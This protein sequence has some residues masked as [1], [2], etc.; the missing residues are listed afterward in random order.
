[1]S[2][3]VLSQEEVDALLSAMN[4]GEVDLEG[5]QGETADVVP[6]DLT[7]QNRILH[8]QFEALDQVYDIF[9]NL[10]RNSLSSSLRKTVEVTLGSSEMVKFSEFLKSFSNPTS[11]NIF[12]MSPLIGSGMLVLKPDLVFPLIDCMFGGDGKSVHQVRE[13]TRIEQG[14]IKRFVNETLKIWQKS[15]RA[16]HSVEVS[17]K[18]TETKPQFVHLVAPDDAVIITA[19]T[20]NCDEFSEN[21]YLC[22]PHIMLEPIKDKLSYGSLTEL[23]VKNKCNSQLQTL[24]KET[25]VSITVEL[26][27]TTR[28]VG[29]LLNLQTGDIINLNAGPQDPI[30]IKVEQITK[31]KGFPGIVKG[32]RAVQITK[33]LRKNGGVNNGDR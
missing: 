6:C 16:V 33:L 30:I 9:I 4:K 1:M 7:S 20:I 3:K 25:S 12:N 2:D 13:F 18:K 24:L 29:D 15:F 8:D 26:G 27:E 19:F 23:E 28:N 22:I 31:Y 14:V 5:G 11:F 10:F 32:N 17:L 21:I